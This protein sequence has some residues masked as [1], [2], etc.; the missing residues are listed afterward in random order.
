[1]KGWGGREDRRERQEKMIG[2]SEKVRREDDKVIE[3]LINNNM[4]DSYYR[5][6][7]NSQQSNQ[8]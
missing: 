7:Y 3:D 4:L 6:E 2:T 5:I 1:M 8:R